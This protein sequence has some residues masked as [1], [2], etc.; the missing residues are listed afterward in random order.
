[1]KNNR[2]TGTGNKVKLTSVLLALT[3]LYMK[4]Q[5]CGGGAHYRQSVTNPSRLKVMNTLQHIIL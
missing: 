5:G 4:M 2:N 3:R 1:M